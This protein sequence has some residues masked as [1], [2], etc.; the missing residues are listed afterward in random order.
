VLSVRP[1]PAESLLELELADAFSQLGF[2]ERQRQA[3]AWR[4]RSAA[5]GYERL[6]LTDRSGRALGRSALVGGGM[7]VLDRP[8]TT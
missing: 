4:E 3:E 6:A 5:L 1:R 7:I 8:D 2:G